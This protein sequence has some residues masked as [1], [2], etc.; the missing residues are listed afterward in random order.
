MQKE[1]R[2]T[3]IR[4]SPGRRTIHGGYSYLTSGELPE[5]RA[6]IEKYLTSARQGLIKDLG[7]TEEDLSTAQVILVDRIVSKLGCI[8]CIEE[9][10]RTNGVMK[11]NRLTP[12]LSGNY[13]AYSNS[14]RLDLMALGIKPEKPIE[15]K[16]LN[17]M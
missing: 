7:P 16:Y 10:A 12:S 1:K 6:Y 15:L 5:N 2:S 17:D 11:G 3:S 9:H 4:L 13:L 14:I 8:R